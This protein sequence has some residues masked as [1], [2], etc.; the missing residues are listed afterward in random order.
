M[1]IKT[2]QHNFLKSKSCQNILISFID[3]VTSSVMDKKEVED[4]IALL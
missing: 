4:E 3:I 2:S 1:V